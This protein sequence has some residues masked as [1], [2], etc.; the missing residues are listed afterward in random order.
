MH[1]RATRSARL[2]VAALPLALLLQLAVPALIASGETAA[3][4]R[5][6]AAASGPGAASVEDTLWDLLRR[7]G[8][9]VLMR[10]VSTEVTA[11]FD[12][13]GFALGDCATQRNLSAFGRDEARGIGAAFRA[14]GVPV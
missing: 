7:G 2:A 13:P 11:G 14:R 10:H 5:A 8:H 12:P 9:V 6:P 1:G 3:A 4:A